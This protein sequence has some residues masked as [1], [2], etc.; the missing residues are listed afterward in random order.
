[1][2]RLSL[3]RWITI[4]G[5]SAAVLTALAVPI[6]YALVSYQE[7]AEALSFKAQLNAS[8]IAK[9]IYIQGPMWIFHGTRLSEL[10]EL[11]KTAEHELRQR[12]F[13]A[14]GVLIL[15]TGSDLPR[16][17]MVRS[18]P[19]VVDGS[20][21]ARI[22]VEM[23]LHEFAE[24]TQIVA[25]GALLLGL[26]IYLA[27]RALPVRLLDETFATLRRRDEDLERQRDEFE[28]AIENLPYGIGMF[29]AAGRLI[30][31]N[32]AFFRMYGLRAEQVLPGTA[33]SAILE[34]R[35][36]RSI[37]PSS[38]GRFREDRFDP[39]GGTDVL[40][41]RLRDGRVIEITRKPM[42]NGGWVAV[43]KDI[44][45]QRRAEDKIAHM[46]HHDALTGLPNRVLL[47]DKLVHHLEVSRP[48]GQ[49]A[50]LCLDLDQ[51]KQVNDTLGH[52]VGDA[53]LGAVARRLRECVRESDIV[54]R[55]GGDEFAVIQTGLSQ[56]SAATTLA[57]RLV[58]QMTVPFEAAGHEVAVFTSI[59]IAI[60]PDDGADAE[61]LLRSAD[62][63][64][65]RT[66]EQGRNGFCFFEPEMDA[67]MHERR[68]LEIDLRKAIVQGGFRLVYQPV[69]NLAHNRIT[70]F[71][72]LLRWHHPV[73]GVVPP[74]QFVPLAEETGLI[75]PIGEWVLRQACVDA[76]RWPDDIRVAINISPVQFRS[77]SLAAAVV[78]ALSTAGLAPDRLEIEIT[79]SSLL[80]NNEAT[81]AVLYQLQGIGVRVAMDDFGTGYS[82]LS[83]LRS[84]PFDKIKIDQSF[85]RDLDRT[86]DAVAIVR[87][88]SSLAAELGMV[89]TAE[90]VDTVSQLERV[91]AEGCSEVQGYL[92]SPPQPASEVPR[93][94]TSMKPRQQAVA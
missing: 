26:L 84:F 48:G 22:D 9:Y 13:D 32:S 93:L 67:R 72:A 31:R 53:L 88:V 69:V 37:Y 35:V 79:E 55:L 4:I 94:L 65:Y 74:T 15:E 28:A 73:R 10:I 80:H 42:A 29:D 39:A 16:P 6:G 24:P 71:E 51:F 14:R 83:Y 2:L 8:R 77:K 41:D 33:L 12:I 58:E 36:S 47:Y 81:L 91:R 50:V 66:K 62:L 1:M 68:N 20:A 7:E 87:A 27:L 23:S 44:T 19:V 17:T 5:T 25:G 86:K 78:S 82:S 57:Q 38:E 3:R 61:Q 30:V 59:G 52:S 89:T 45:E 64:L 90:G 11:P 56:P 85:V 46:A 75:V 60:A 70:G 40:V 18:A 63:A 34:Q 92:F 43:H 49:I 76:A 21:V 54:A